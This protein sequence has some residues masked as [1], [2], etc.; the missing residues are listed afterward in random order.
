MV[1]I[2]EK[3]FNYT[4][5]FPSKIIRDY[6]NVSETYLYQGLISQITHIIISQLTDYLQP[7]T[8]NEQN[9]L[10]IK[11]IYEGERAFII[12]NGP[13]L[14]KIDLNKLKSEVT[15]AS[16]SIF[17]LFN[18]TDFRPTFYTVEDTLVAED[19]SKEINKLH[20]MYKI[21]PIDLKKYLI[22]D[23]NTIYINFQRNYKNFPKFSSNFAKRVYW[24]GTVTFLNLQLAY[25]LGSREVYLVG[26][27]H[28][29]K[30]PSPA[31]IVEGNVITSQTADIN[32][33]DPEYFGPGYR[34][35]DPKVDRMEQ[36][37]IEAK[38]FYESHG[39]KIYNA[40]VGGKLEVFPRIDFN[41][42]F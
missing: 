11:N 20:G 41:K 32:H 30:Q 3:F 22:P 34:W 6:H 1:D 28:N 36:A 24:G 9:R 21:F 33:F 38:R 14:N 27:D 5:D 39:G 19:R 8:K 18:E 25:Y 2:F 37:Y 31:D 13:S 12:G 35:H 17:L 10:K 7:I 23:E 15:I 29:Y 4:P 40:T 42:L 16:N 26:I